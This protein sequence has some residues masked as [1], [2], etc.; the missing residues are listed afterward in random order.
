MII[1]TKIIF[2]GDIDRCKSVLGI[3][4][5]RLFV[6]QER[7]K[8]SNGLIQ[9]GWQRPINLITGEVIRLAVSFNTS[10]IEIIAEGYGPDKSYKLQEEGRKCFC[11]CNISL[12]IIIKIAEELKHS[13]QWIDVIACNHEKLYVVYENI[14]PSDF[15]RY[16]PGQKVIVMAYYD[17]LYDCK[18]KIFSSTG[19]SPKKHAEIP[20][21]DTW[22]TTYRIVPLCA[23]TIPQWIK[24]G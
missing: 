16:E 19:C 20:E 7:L 4:R 14:I 22:R 3:A 13:I 21:N 8:R 12:G 2:R 6:F 17:F 10:V 5:S 24:N 1:P 23:L 18:N 15:T 9:Q 11:D